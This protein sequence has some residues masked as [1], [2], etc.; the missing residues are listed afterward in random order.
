MGERPPHIVELASKSESPEAVDALP[1][2]AAARLLSRDAWARAFE[3]EERRLARYGR[4]CS[5]VAIGL[6]GLEALSLRIGSEAA[7]R[8]VEP[9]VETLTTRARAADLVC[10][11]DR[12]RFVALLPETD[13]P[14][15]RAYAARLARATALWLAAAPVPVGL[16]IG[17]GSPPPGGTLASALVVAYRRMDV[18]RAHRPGQ[19]GGQVSFQRSTTLVSCSQPRTDTVAT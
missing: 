8:L 2:P 15:A 3:L 18:D 19:P 9:L 4:P 5:V 6:D 17:W 14:G 1:P 16:A 12:T 13:G 7:E 11:I 10:R